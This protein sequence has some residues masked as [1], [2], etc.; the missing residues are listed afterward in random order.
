VVQG[1]EAVLAG[2]HPS[3]LRLEYASSSP[4]GEHWYELVVEPLRRPQGGAVV[5][6]IDC[7]A[8]KR[9][10]EDAQMHRAEAAHAARA[11]TLGELAAGLAHELNQ[12]L[13]AILTNVQASRR[14][15]L[16]EPP[17]I[18]LLR[19][20]LDDIAA[21]D[22][23]ASEII[24]R[25][26]ALLKKGRTEIQALDLNELTR[27]VLRLLASDAI[28]RR[29]RVRPLLEPDLPG[30]CGD[31]VQLQQVILNLLVNGLEAMTETVPA[32][33]H[34]EIRTVHSDDS[35]VEIMV[36]DHG[37]GI[38]SEVL[39]RL[40]EP[41]FTTKRDGL[42]MGLSICR[43]IAEAHG[44]HLQASNNPDGGA[45]FAFRL[46]MAGASRRH[47]DEAAHESRRLRRR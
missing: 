42:G 44:G 13:A 9:A 3:G 32:R 27:D 7:T 29:V 1:I 18:E 8:R 6:H 41:F 11:A 33:R 31:R 35:W 12:P 20:I 37:P 40:Y 25:M 2:E 36:R 43:S 15:L 34:L 28:L 47:D 17:R 14:L 22:V 21:D 19:E 16:T 10:E 46:P 45:T 39:S 23:R 26:R 4:A 24:R 5:A 30:V 38:P